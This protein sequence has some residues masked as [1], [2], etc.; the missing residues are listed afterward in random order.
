M[1]SIILYY[2]RLYYVMIMLSQVFGN[3]GSSGS[4][5]FRF[6]EERQMHEAP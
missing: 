2:I 3:P 6:S 5:V 4:A 1:I